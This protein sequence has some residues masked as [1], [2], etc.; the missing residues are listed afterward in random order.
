[1]YK[2]LVLFVSGLLLSCSAF[3]IHPYTY[4]TQLA[5]GTPQSLA[6]AVGG[7][8]EAQ[9]FKVI[10][11]YF[12][13]NQ[14]G[15]GVVIATD[16]DTL[17][18]IGEFGAQ[19]IV[20]ATIRVGVK[21]DG[22]VSYTTPDYWYRAIFRDHFGDVEKTAV[23]V[24]NRL[25]SAL[26]EGEGFGGNESARALKNYHYMIGMERLDDYKNKLADAGSFNEAV[27]TVRENLAKKVGDTAKV[28]EVVL[29]GKQ[30]AVFGVAFNNDATGDAVW[31]KK[32]N[33]PEAVAALPY[34]IFIVGKEID[35]LHARFR[36]AVS[37]PDTSMGTFM[38]ISDIPG[39]IREVMEQLAASGGSQ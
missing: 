17:K 25:S 1:M 26:G 31:L 2:R 35:A 9:G 19:T 7:K 4:G 23:N 37:F 22:T 20:G 11:Q 3:A 5:A 21:A 29:P 28:Y 14:P 13:K 18:S 24:Q 39:Q 27:K 10:G 33:M 8:L 36:L 12:P 30:L 32:I 16:A 34:E 38:H 15:Y 6:T